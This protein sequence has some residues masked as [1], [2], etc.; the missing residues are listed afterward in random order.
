MHYRELGRSGL[1]ISE[2]GFGCGDNAGLMIDGSLDDQCRVVERALEMGI[3]YFDTAAG[4]GS[5]KS[6]TSLGQ[7]LRRVGVRPIINTKVEVEPSQVDN[8]AGAIVASVEGSLERLQVDY[9]DVVMIHNSPVYKRVDGYRGWM[10]MTIDEYLGPSGALEGMEQLRRDGRARF[11]GV[12]NERPD[13]EL[14]RRLL[15]T[16]RFDLL[17]V[18]CNLLNPTAAMPSP[19]GLRVDLDNGDV[20]SYAAARRVGVAIF[21]PMARGVLTD[22]AAADGSR[23]PLAGTAITRNPDSYQALLAKGRALGFLSRE[24]RSLSQAAVRFLLMNAGVTAILGGFTA[25]EHV[26]DLAAA[27]EMEPLSDLELARIAM[28]WR[29]NFGAW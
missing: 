26:D 28:V 23:H 24:G 14:V 5:H 6:E 4:Y 8:V 10:P 17:N 13:V 2:I 21:S 15:D 20:I 25:P 27:A 3:N 11:F 12:V 19:P 9:V 16:G 22:Q 7:V 18:Q 29:S 1:R